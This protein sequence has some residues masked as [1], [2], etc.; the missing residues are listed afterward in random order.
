MNIAIIKKLYLP[1]SARWKC[2]MNGSLY[3]LCRLGYMNFQYR[4]QNTKTNSTAVNESPKMIAGSTVGGS[5][6]EFSVKHWIQS[7][8]NMLSKSTVII[9]IEHEWFQPAIRKILRLQ[10]LKETL[11]KT[12][13]RIYQLVLWSLIY[14]W[15]ISYPYPRCFYVTTHTSR[16]DWIQGDKN[17]MSI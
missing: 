7:F 4:Q 8:T 17:N 3:K 16:Y 5:W 10:D 11:H 14:T 6:N 2:L 1:L 15:F 12:L 13:Q 9:A